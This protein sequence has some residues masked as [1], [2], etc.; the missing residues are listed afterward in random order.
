MLDRVHLTESEELKT[1]EQWARVSGLRY[2]PLFSSGGPHQSIPEPIHCKL[3][4]LPEK[5]IYAKKSPL[6]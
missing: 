5:L 6:A 2:L 1:I 4:N 3:L